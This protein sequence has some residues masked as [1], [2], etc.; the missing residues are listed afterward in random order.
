MKW[1]DLKT[2]GSNHYKKDPSKIE[3][4][5]L[6]K[7]GDMLRDFAIG[8]IIKYAYRNRSQV[9]KLNPADMEKIKHYADMLLVAEGE[10]I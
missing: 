1:E 2:R 9:G 7:D 5:D 10:T 6:L 4:I 8:N 3:P